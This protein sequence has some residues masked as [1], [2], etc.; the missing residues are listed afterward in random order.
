MSDCANRPSVIF[1][2]YDGLQMLDLA[3]PAEVFGMVSQVSGSAGYDLRYIAPSGDRLGSSTFRLCGEPAAATPSLIHTLVVPGGSAAA[4]RAALGDRAFVSWLQAAAARAERVVSVCTGA[5]LLA[6]IGALDGRRVATHWSAT[7]RL[8]ACAP[9]ATVDPDALYVED[10]R[11]WTSAGV[12]AGIDLALA[13]V[14]RDFGAGC[15]LAVARELVVPLVR[16]GGQSQFSRPLALQKNAGVDLG[17]LIPWLEERLHQPITV[18]E[19]AAALCMSER[20]FQRRC[21]QRLGLSPARLLAELRL[22]RARALLS[23][24]TVPLSTVAHQSGFG[25][26]SSLSK[27]FQRRFGLAPTSYRRSF[28]GAGIPGAAQ[29]E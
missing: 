25:D 27:A 4:V 1:A 12:S 21:T 13:L 26:P 24:P 15:A 20:T 28:G 17:R 18:S 16:P 7:D 23:E 9:R 5:F 14:T 8:V 3:G 19:M 2:L 22:E 29:R 6:Y 11:I 10:G